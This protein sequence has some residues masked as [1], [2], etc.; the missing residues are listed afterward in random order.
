[1]GQIGRA[2]GLAIGTAIQ[3]AVQSSREGS[4]VVDIDGNVG[5]HAYLQGLHAAQWLN[6][7]DLDS[8]NSRTRL[9]TCLQDAWSKTGR[10]WE[11]RSLPFPCAEV[12]HY[13]SSLVAMSR[14]TVEAV[15]MQDTSEL[16][17]V[18]H[19]DGHAEVL[20]LRATLIREALCIATLTGV[21]DFSTRNEDNS[22]RTI[23]HLLP[24]T[25]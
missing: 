2:V 7:S 19:R 18:I 15:N 25:C 5:D 11:R 10:C 13:R 24:K 1:M 17:A 20:S 12:C 21:T 6:V 8:R 16:P 3:V 14:N 4:N 22:K 23:H 9:A